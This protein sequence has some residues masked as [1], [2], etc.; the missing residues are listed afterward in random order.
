MGGNEGGAVTF[1]HISLSSIASQVTCLPLLTLTVRSM[2][3]HRAKL[4]SA[5]RMTDRSQLYALFTD[6]HHVG[7]VCICRSTV[8]PTPQSIPNQQLGSRGGGGGDAGGDGGGGTVGG[9]G[10]R[11]Q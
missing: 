1:R 5:R 7:G 2:L 9:N 11:F 6:P 8:L 10:A 4:P 3:T